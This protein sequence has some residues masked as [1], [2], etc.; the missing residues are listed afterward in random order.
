MYREHQV[1]SGLSIAFTGLGWYY[2]TKR[3]L[4]KIINAIFTIEIVLLQTSPASVPAVPEAKAV[5]TAGTHP[6][7]DYL[8]EPDFTNSSNFEM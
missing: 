5:S 1:S 7:N 3:F 2:I 6:P 8:S 4:L